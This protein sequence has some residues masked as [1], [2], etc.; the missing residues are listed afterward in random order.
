M[1]AD[2]LYADAIGDLK[3]GP[4]AVVDVV[5][6]AEGN[7]HTSAREMMQECLSGGVLD[8]F[9]TALS[10]RIGRLPAEYGGNAQE[11]CLETMYVGSLNEGWNLVV[12]SVGAR[13]HQERVMSCL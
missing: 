10:A 11:K 2:P 8:G 13:D 3:A 1:I 6:K 4:R 9:A 5:E 12:A 7:L